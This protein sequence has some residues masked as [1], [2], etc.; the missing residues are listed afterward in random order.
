MMAYGHGNFKE[1]YSGTHQLQQGSMLWDLRDFLASLRPETQSESRG[2]SGRKDQVVLLIFG[3]ISVVSCEVLA[4]Q[5][6]Q[7]RGRKGL[8]IG[9]GVGGEQVEDVAAPIG[10]ALALVVLEGTGGDL[11]ALVCLAGDGEVDG[12]Q[13]QRVRAVRVDDGECAR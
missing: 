12:Q 9:E 2:G 8:V 7:D 5:A 13:P 1:F 10:V 3:L 6:A 4:D 11:A